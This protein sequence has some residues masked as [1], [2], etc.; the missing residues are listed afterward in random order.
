MTRGNRRVTG[1]GG[2][3]ALA[4]VGARG[5]QTQRA[6]HSP[7]AGASAKP[8]SGEAIVPFKIHVSDSVLADLKQ[9][10]QRARFADEIPEVGW[11][12]G[13]NLA[14]LKELVTYWRDKY[15]WRAQERRLN[16]YDQFKTNIDGL[17]IQL[18]H[19]PPNV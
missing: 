17:D 3:V 2:V 6:S 12:Y 18:L 11:D 4:V 9:R 1:F 19:Q 14:Y 16:Q 7:G 5:G 15:D 13:T 8:V 10:L